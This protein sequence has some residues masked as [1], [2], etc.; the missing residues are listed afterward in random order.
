MKLTDHSLPEA[1]SA[2]IL[3]YSKVRLETHFTSEW[4]DDFAWLGAVVGTGELS[5]LQENLEE[6]L[7]IEGA[8]GGVERSSWDV[9]DTCVC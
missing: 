8:D 1:C 7:G 9:L 3:R 5:A 4:G 6:H 2:G